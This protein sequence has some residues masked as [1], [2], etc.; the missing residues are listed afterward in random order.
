MNSAD[1]YR[2]RGGIVQHNYSRA[3]NK[4]RAR[5][6]CVIAIDLGNLIE[7]RVGDGYVNG[8]AMCKAHGKLMGNYH[9]TASAKAFAKSL[10]AT[11]GIPIVG[12]TISKPGGT[13]AGGG[14]WVHPTIA[15]H[16]AMWCSPDFAV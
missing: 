8:T 11:I 12:L 14:T 9:A 6:G 16:L 3:L 4:H 1:F 2:S 5:D 13:E 10:A 7:Q 15:I